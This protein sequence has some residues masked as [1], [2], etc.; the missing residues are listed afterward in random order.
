MTYFH[1]NDHERVRFVHIIFLFHVFTFQLA[2]LFLAGTI[3]D[4]VEV[5]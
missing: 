1:A 5:Q 4:L 2:T 3:Q